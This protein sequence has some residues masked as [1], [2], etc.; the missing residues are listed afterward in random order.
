LAKLKRTPLVRWKNLKYFNFQGGHKRHE[1][2]TGPRSQ[3]GLIGRQ[4]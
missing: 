2:T 4:P 3:G 1:R